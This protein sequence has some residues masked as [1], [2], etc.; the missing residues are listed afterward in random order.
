MSLAVVFTISTVLYLGS[1]FL[2]RLFV[3]DEK[4]IAQSTLLMR[5]LAPL[6]FLYLGG[7]ILSG[8]IRGTGETF[9]PMVMTLLGTCA[10]RIFWILFVPKRF[11]TPPF[12]AFLKVLNPECNHLGRTTWGCKRSPRF[13]GGGHRP[14]WAPAS[15]P[16]V[17]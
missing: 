15:D 13:G 11:N 4:V 7:E 1:G 3:D 16:V 14:G 2:G 9:K 8:A 6:Y 10:C 5:F 12:R 17:P